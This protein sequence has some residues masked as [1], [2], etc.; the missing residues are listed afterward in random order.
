MSSNGP[1]T[2]VAANQYA[3]LITKCITTKQLKLA[4]LF[5]SHLIKTAL[6][7]NIFLTNRLID[8]YTKCNSI[9]SAQKTFDDLPAKNTHTW[10]TIITAYSRIGQFDYAHKLLD[11]I[12]KP[13]ICSYNTLISG[14]THHG[15][16]KEAITLF[17]NMQKQGGNLFFDDFTLSSL[18]GACASLGTLELLRQLHGLIVLFGLNINAIM[19]NSLINAYGK[20]GEPSSAYNVFNQMRERNIVSWTSIV[21]AYTRASRL[22]EAC[23][24]FDKMPTKNTISWTALISGFAQNGRGNEAL[25]LFE[26]MLKEGIAPS[27]FT[28]VA[29]LSACS[30]LTLIEKG[31]QIHGNVVSTKLFNLFLYNALIDMYCK[32]GDTNSAKTLFE[33]IPNK[34]IVTWN[35]LITG[36]AQN[37]QGEESLVLFKKM[38]KATLK[39]NHVTFLGVLSACNHTGQIY[40]GLSLLDSM[41]KNH[42]VAPRVDHYAV[43]IDLLG[44]KNRLDEAM[45]LIKKAP[46]GLGHIGIWGALLGGSRVHGN[47]D[48]AKM[49]AEALFELEPENVGRYVMLSNIYAAKNKWEDA[50][51]VRRLMKERGLKKEAA[52]SWIEVRNKKHEFGANDRSHCQMEEIYEVIGVLAHQLKEAGYLPDRNNLLILNEDDDAY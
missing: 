33:V 51:T 50:H 35:S 18:I 23:L 36:F 19:Y 41:E 7:F 2:A 29:I 31:K 10:N 38:T 4:Q 17:K 5:H 22:D 9:E 28:F 32:C 16:H 11:I 44:R 48:I 46:H 25:N 13:S 42:G 8:L 43:L 21:D 15:Y 45:Q 52:F 14:L 6:T 26:Q 47:L 39:P 37:G 20:C 34:D 49:A 3:P 27:E 24:I 12:P 30:D 40:E 1:T